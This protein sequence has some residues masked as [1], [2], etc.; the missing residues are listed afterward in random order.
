M[1]KLSVLII[2]LTAVMFFNS[3][4]AQKRTKPETELENEEIRG[5]VGLEPIAPKPWEIPGQKIDSIVKRVRPSVSKATFPKGE[6]ALAGKSV[7]VS[8]GHGWYWTGT[9]WTTQRGYSEGVVEDLSNAESVNQFVVSCLMRSGAHV[10]P[11]REIDM[12]SEMVIVDNDDGNTHPERGTYEETGDAGLFSD[13]SLDAF[14]YPSLPISDATNPF[15]LGTNRLMNTSATSTASIRYTFNVPVSGYYNVYISYTSYTERAPDAHY[16]VNHPGGQAH[17]RVD[18]RHHGSTWVLLGRFWFKAGSSAN[19]GS[20]SIENDSAYA[21]QNVQV[22]ADAVRIGGGMGVIDRGGG[23]SNKPRYEECCRYHAQFSGAPSTVY[24]SSSEDNNDDVSC[25]SRMAAWVHESG[26]DA[27]YVSWHTNA[28]GGRGTDTYVYSNNGPDGSYTPGMG[29]AGSDEL[30]A[31][32][33]DTA[34]TNFQ[35]HFEPTWRDRGVKSAYFGEINPAYHDADVPAALM[36]MLFHDSAEDMVYY[37]QIKNRYIAGR[38]VCH[39]VIRYFADRDGITPAL[40]P[41]S[42]EGLSAVNSGPGSVSITWNPPKTDPVGG[43]DPAGYRVYISPVEKAWGDGVYVEGTS[44]TLS[45]LIA[46]QV[47]YIRVASVNAGGESEVSPP[48]A[49]GVSPSGYA[50]VLLIDAFTAKNEGLNIMQDLGYTNPVH[51]L[52]AKKMHNFREGTTVHAQALGDADMAFDTIHIEAF[53]PA[54]LNWAR[55]E[56][57]DFIHGRGQTV[58]PGELWTELSTFVTGGGNLF[59]SG[60][61]F[62]DALSNA[63]RNDILD[64]LGTASWSVNAS[65]YSVSGQGILTDLAATGI[66][67]G[68]GDAY[69]PGN[70]NIIVPGTA[71]SAA[72]YSG[73]GNAGSVNDTAGGSVF[74]LGFPFENMVSEDSRSNLMEAVTDYFQVETPVPDAGPDVTEDVIE[75]TGTPDSGECNPNYECKTEKVVGCHCR[76]GTGSTG[77]GSIP[78]FLILAIIGLALV[79]RKFS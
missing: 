78:V 21:D 14:A 57:V 22:S 47:L 63:G 11:V 61:N 28:G 41:E 37:R 68:S 29:T 1:K 60:S 19:Y 75:D 38:A 58:F 66:D 12:T 34:I 77:P 52:I 73:G 43:D 18:Q 36:E 42:P 46:G 9:R 15:S 62:F 40:P 54:T 17:F 55:Y 33:Q 69:Y 59:V 2:A 10:V 74:V 48:V 6:G 65:D 70:M 79:G 71:A 8:P 26:E 3:G 35:F 27:V 67:N 4:S 72:V 16:I 76:A 53:T 64:L 30:A 39:G 49:V 44:H 51:R 7:Y 31:M 50:N 32:L 20:V 24:N 23:T 13:S 25:R 56:M 5:P 45:N